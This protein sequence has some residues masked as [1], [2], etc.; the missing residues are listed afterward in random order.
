MSSPVARRFLEGPAAERLDRS[1]YLGVVVGAFVLRRPLNPYY[2]LNVSDPAV[3]LT[4]VIGTSNLVR[5]GSLNGHHLYYVPRYLTQDD[6]ASVTVQASVRNHGA[7]S[8]GP[9]RLHLQIPWR[10][11]A[12]RRVPRLAPG[13]TAVVPVRLSVPRARAG[14]PAQ[15][16]VHVDAA[17]AEQHHKDNDA[18]VSARLLAAPAVC[19]HNDGIGVNV[20]RG[21]NACS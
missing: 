17:Q 9:T 2:I 7:A 8:S 3:D 18:S 5:D 6:P 13:A 12:R 1:E 10:A 19:P 21:M 15:F 16:R 4:G 14:K 11:T 20:T